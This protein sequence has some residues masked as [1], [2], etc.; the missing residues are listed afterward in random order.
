MLLLGLN[1]Y[2]GSIVASSTA[3][4]TPASR[5]WRPLYNLAPRLRKL[6]ALRLKSSA[7]PMLR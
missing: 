2:L 5:K 4:G 1:E 6:G 3:D 7:R